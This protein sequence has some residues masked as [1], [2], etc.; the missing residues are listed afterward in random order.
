M[1]TF[2]TINTFLG[3]FDLKTAKEKN[4]NNNKKTEKEKKEKSAI[5]AILN[6]NFLANTTTNKVYFYSHHWKCSHVQQQQQ[7]PAISWLTKD[8][9]T[10]V[11]SV[12]L[13]SPFTLPFASSLTSYL[14]PT[15]HTPWECSHSACWDHG[16]F[17]VLRL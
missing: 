5:T 6:A 7:K 17:F 14:S 16:I 1:R 12:W 10:S 11:G 2:T 15:L 4:N 9:P 3:I 13:S 8:F